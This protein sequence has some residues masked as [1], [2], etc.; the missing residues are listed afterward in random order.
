MLENSPSV[1]LNTSALPITLPQN[2]TLQMRLVDGIPVMKATAVVQARIHQL[3]DKER[4]SILS[5][6]EQH[7]LDS[8]EQLDDY[9]SFMNRVVRNLLFSKSAILIT[10]NAA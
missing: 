3:L 7:E 1:S 4:Q 2:V 9:L 8:Y 6:S 10:S 5:A